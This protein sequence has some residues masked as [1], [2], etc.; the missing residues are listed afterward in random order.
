MNFQDWINQKYIDYLQTQGERRTVEEFASWIGV[1]KSTMS[2][3]MNGIGTPG[4][5]KSIDLLVSRFGEETYQV[6]GK[7]KIKMNYSPISEAPADV[8][9]RITAALSHANQQYRAAAEQGTDLSDEQAEHI[10]REAMSKYGF[11]ENDT[12]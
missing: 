10:L 4:R 1:G 6:I 2:Q 11:F 7:Q 12:P 9:K 5:Q 3:W 8:R